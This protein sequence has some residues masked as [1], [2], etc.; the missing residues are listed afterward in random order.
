MS[1]VRRGARVRVARVRWTAVVALALALVGAGAR[2]DGSAPPAAAPDEGPV[3]NISKKIE[4]F[5]LAKNPTARTLAEKAGLVAEPGPEPDFVVNARPEGDEDYIPVGRKEVDQ[6]IKPK[7]AADLKKMEAGFAAV[8]A[9]HDAIRSTFPPA[10]KAVA[11]AE[12]A[13]AAKAAKP[14][15]KT[16]EPAAPPPG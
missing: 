4:K 13:K 10:V 6:P 3:R 15:K 14:K 1:I 5:S 12:A 8:Q 11:A 2:A 7:T 16:P 9:R